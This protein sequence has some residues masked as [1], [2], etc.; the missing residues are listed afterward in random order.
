[1]LKAQAYFRLRK[2]ELCY[3]ATEQALALN[4]KNAKAIH[5]KGNI[6][7]DSGENEK[8][9]EF[10]LKAIEIDPLYANP[11]NELGIVYSELKDFK[12]AIKYYSK[13]IELDPNY[14]YPYNVWVLPTKN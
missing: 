2:I 9:K 4:P 14:E 7:Q 5:Y 11:Y 13:A 8:A 6:Y 1:M 10:F 3:E 12:N